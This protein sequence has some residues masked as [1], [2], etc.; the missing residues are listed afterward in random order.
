[1]MHVLLG[2]ASVSCT[3]DCGADRAAHDYGGAALN[4]RTAGG[5]GRRAMSHARDRRLQAGS[6]R[7]PL[8]AD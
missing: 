5:S 4:I 6:Q 3:Q 1:M 7:A 2:V 8:R